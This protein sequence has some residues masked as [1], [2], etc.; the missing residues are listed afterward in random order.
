MIV[1]LSLLFTSPVEPLWP[2]PSGVGG[3]GVTSY[4]LYGTD[5]PLQ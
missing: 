5:V 3:G 2:P 1:E 4:I